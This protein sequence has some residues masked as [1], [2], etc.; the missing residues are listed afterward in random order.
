MVY[1]EKESKKTYFSCLEILSFNLDSVQANVSDL[2]DSYALW[3]SIMHLNYSVGTSG[4]KAL[5]SMLYNCRQKLT[6][7]GPLAPFFSPLQIP[8]NT[9]FVDNFAGLL[10]NFAPQIA[11]YVLFNISTESVNAAATYCAGTPLDSRNRTVGAK[12][13]VIVNVP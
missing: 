5:Y 10:S 3:L 6:I 11:G 12:S 13:C 1:K 9:T 2:T 4:S 8:I 7:C